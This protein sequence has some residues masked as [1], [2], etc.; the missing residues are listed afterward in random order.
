MPQAG[1]QNVGQLASISTIRNKKHDGKLLEA[2]P[3][4]F[5]YT[6]L[7][8]QH[9]AH[10]VVGSFQQ[11]GGHQGVFKSN[12]PVLEK[13][14]GDRERQFYDEAAAG[15]WPT[16]F[17]PGYHGDTG[18]GDGRIGIENLI[19]G[20]KCPCV[21]DLKMGVR[22]VESSEHNL[23]KKV[24]MSALDVF[25]KTA[26]TGVRLEGLSVYRALEG[27]KIKTNK[28]QSHAISAAM[29]LNLQDVLM[30]F[31]T[32]ESGV[33]R[34]VAIRFLSHLRHLL[35]HFET[36][37]D[38]YLFVGSSIL[39]I[40]DNDN[41]APHSRW[42]RAL[43]RATR[44]PPDAYP[45]L[46][47]RTRVNVRMIDFAH[48]GPLQAGQ[49]RDTGYITGLK[50]IIT[51]VTAVIGSG[52]C[53]K[54]PI[55]SLAAAAAEAVTASGPSDTHPEAAPAAAAPVSAAGMAVASP[56]AS[57]ASPAVDDA[58]GH[59]PPIPRGPRHTF[60]LSA[61]A[62]SAY[63]AISPPP[64]APAHDPISAAGNAGPTFWELMGIPRMHDAVWDANTSTT[65][66]AKYPELP[67]L[68]GGG[69][70]W[71]WER[72]VGTRAAV[73]PAANACGPLQ[74]GTGKPR[75]LANV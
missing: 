23:M 58:P 40:Y 46:R 33:R 21:M 12:G 15:K 6:P 56:V 1:M 9:Q 35:H 45:A 28:A 22:T 57:P 55:F 59:N 61:A 39:L 71:Q 74:P 29:N 54:Q 27:G 67:A 25:T 24:K 72:D 48:V 5:T 63:P 8:Q 73:V 19:H 64:P 53:P 52:S 38:Q 47:R 16:S 66:A 31:L 34:D 13:K 10:G 50:S 37:N 62:P 65:G 42:A 41:A 49:Q 36:V 11:A 43:E 51:A 60:K 3:M 70:Q 30:F 4:L 7:E 20:M 32:D 68:T 17:L 69:P 18:A 14:V 26:F 75:E 2:S 44:L